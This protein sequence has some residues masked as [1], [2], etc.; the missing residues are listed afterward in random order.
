LLANYR[1]D[2]INSQLNKE[3]RVLKINPDT[4]FINFN[5][6][7][8]KMV[9]VKPNL[10]LEFSKLYNLTDSISIQP[11]YIAV[12]AEAEVVNKID[13]VETQAMTLKN[14][15]ASTSIKL[16]LVKKEEYK[17]VEFSQSTVKATINVTK[18]TEASLELPVEV[19]NLP[20]GYSFKTFP[21]KVMVKFNVAFENYEKINATSF[22][23]VVDYKKIDKQSNKLKVQL[24]KVPE[25]LRNIK[26][27]TEKVEY[28]IS[29]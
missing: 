5:R 26:L 4:I 1:M 24:L 21:D 16:P 7:I 18:Y 27:V 9:P 11:K 10:S 13:F 3:T 20:L 2:K 25:G 19:E 15:N 8:S 14:I 28:I 23:A 29:K 22:R 17:H 6:K 12:S